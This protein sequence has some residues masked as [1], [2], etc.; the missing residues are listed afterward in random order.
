MFSIKL[1]YLKS[2]F[3]SF[4][5]NRF[6][7]SYSNLLIIFST[8]FIDLNYSLKE[9]SSFLY[10]RGINVLRHLFVFSSGLLNNNF[11]LLG[12]KFLYLER[13]FCIG[14]ISRNTVREHKLK[15][16]ILIK[17]FANANSF[18]LLKLINSILLDWTFKYDCIDFPWDIWGELDVYLYKLLWKWARRRHPRRPN[19]WVYMKY[20]KSFL[21]GWRFFA[22][23]NFSGQ[24]IF[25]RSHSLFYR[26]VYRLPLSVQ[27]YDLF[28]TRKIE[29]VFFKKFFFIFQGL[30]RA[31]WKRQFGLCF[32][33][34]KTF[35][36]I[37][38]S[39]VK[40]CSLKKSDN[41]LYNLVLL[42]NYC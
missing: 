27:P 37:S 16:K 22:F 34:R 1:R 32:N 10:L 41:S 21:G 40:V 25:L 12:W 18:I 13:N 19:T 36:Y 30:F 7:I 38:F 28:N 6:L 31:L 3:I 2:D 11:E 20:W 5:K 9:I 35:T 42:H 15:L 26:P 33:C 14:Q 17:D 24:I 39:N 29:L 4:F 23:D 8:S